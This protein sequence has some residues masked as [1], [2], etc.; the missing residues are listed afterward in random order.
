MFRLV[1]AESELGISFNRYWRPIDNESDRDRCDGVKVDVSP[2]VQK[3]DA[4]FKQESKLNFNTSIS[5]A[6]SFS[7]TSWMVV[8]SVG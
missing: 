4:K 1:V 6:A 5:E 2:L 8:T 3:A 7:D